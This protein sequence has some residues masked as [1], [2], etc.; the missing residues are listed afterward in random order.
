MQPVSDRAIHQSKLFVTL[1]LATLFL[2]SF[3]SIAMKVYDHFLGEPKFAAG[4]AIGPVPVEGLTREMAVEKL[5]LAVETWRSQDTIRVRLEKKEKVLSSTAFSIDVLSS[6]QSAQLNGVSPLIVSLEQE[7]INFMLSSLADASFIQEVDR[8]ELDNVLLGYATKL[9]TQNILLDLKDFH[10]RKSAPVVETIAELTVQTQRE[11]SQLIQWIPKLT[12]I[13]IPAESTV[14]LLTILQ[15]HHIDP[16]PSVALD[17]IASAIYQ[18]ILPTNFEVLERNISRELPPYIKLGYEAK[19]I[20]GKYDL[21]FHNPNPSD[22]K[23]GLTY[24]SGELRLVISGLPLPN[25]YTILL[26]EERS[27]QPKTVIHYN[28]QLG[29]TEKNVKVEGQAGKY[30]KVYRKPASTDKI[31][32]A[33]DFYPPIHRVEERNVSE[34]LSVLQEDGLTSMVEKER[35]LEPSI[36]NSEEPDEVEEY[37]D[38]HVIRLNSYD[39][40][41]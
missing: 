10:T 1:V 12:Q 4:A 28:S 33:E 37:N 19:V 27:F 16:L 20:P 9:E 15:E 3:Q 21:V 38:H 11:D 31:L 7:D 40:E 35:S 24:R 41:F 32:V 30:V 14:S 13:T 8:N 39:K 34:Q 6:V 23:F 17:T 25:D 26:E 2:F 5:G 29:D 22:Y 36:G 18:A